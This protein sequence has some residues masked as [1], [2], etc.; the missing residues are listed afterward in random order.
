MNKPKARAQTAAPPYSPP[1]TFPTHDAEL[2]ALA[3]VE[4]Q[5]RG[6]R[7]MVE[8]RRYCV[9]ILFQMRAVRAALVRVERNILQTYLNTCARRAL[10]GDSAEEREEKIQ[11]ILTLFDCNV[12]RKKGG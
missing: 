1:P 2:D 6:V 7:K 5:V 9:D 8:E 3:R 12:V 11:E 4:G 10:A